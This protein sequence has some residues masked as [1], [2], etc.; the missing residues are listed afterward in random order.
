VS[1]HLSIDLRR[2]PWIRRLAADYADTFDPLAPFFAGNPA[3]PAAWTAAIARAQAHPRRHAAVSSLLVEQQRRRGAPGAAIAAAERLAD[4]RAVAILTGQQAGLFGGPLFTLLKALTAIRLADRVAREHQVPAIAVFW[5]DAEDHDWEEVRACSVLDANLERRTISLGKPDGAG[6]RP[7]ASVH[8][9]G[10]AAAAVD[11]LAELLAPTEFT[12]ALLASVRGV[13]APGAGMA[14]AFGR[15]L[16][17]VM[18]DLGLVV[19]D[20]S[21][22]AAKPIA[23]DLFVRELEHPGDTARLAADMGQLLRERGYHAQVAPQDASVALFHLD[24]GR[25][26][27]RTHEGQFII[28][29]TSVGRHAL[30][31]RAREQPASFSPN[32]LL[33]P[34]VQDTLF[35]TVAYVPGPNE[36]A[37]L[38]QLKP[39]YERFGVPMPLFFPRATATL[40]DSAGMRF[41]NRYPVPFEA[42][43]PDDEAL[44]NHLL[45]SHLPSSVEQAFQDA[46]A[47]IDGRMMA[48]IEAV[49]AIDPTLQGAARSTLGRMQH[50]LQTLHSKIIHA[51]KRHDETLRRQFRRTRAQVFPGGA[52]QERSVG[53]IYFLNR[54]GPALVTRLLE[55]L[56]LDLGR[57]WVLTI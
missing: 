35:P 48:L 40:I 31:T 13:Y 44:L 28:G 6:D 27:I 19:Y 52:P 21:D 38:A 46:V 33:R 24:G 42:L 1:S 43:Q 23:A 26:P 3:A 4:P 36:L 15:W 53:F 32:V 39:V 54:Y 29:D 56:P 18:G 2:F 11:T 25:R 41:L 57:H 45:E 37:Y 30:I 12:E 17:M 51:A 55:E 14:D 20:A 7:V 9:D 49:P 47:S 34:V 10:S 8:L 16:E 5:I 50:D 22:P